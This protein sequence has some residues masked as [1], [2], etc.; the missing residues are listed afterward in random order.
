M[1]SC[2]SVLQFL[3]H[4]L[5]LKNIRQKNSRDPN[6]L[7]FLCS[8]LGLNSA[9][10]SDRRF[11]TQSDFLKYLFQNQLHRRSIK[12]LS[13]VCPDTNL[14]LNSSFPTSVP[15]CFTLV[16][17]NTILQTTVMSSPSLLTRILQFLPVRYL[18]IGQ[19]VSQI[20]KL[21]CKIGRA[22]L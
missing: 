18:S 13:E 16:A 17:T 5:E 8:S 12:T 15:R 21:V 19:G 22:S 9:H 3:D 2:N 10:A 1:V 11:P 20:W 6:S 7:H 4:I 14:L